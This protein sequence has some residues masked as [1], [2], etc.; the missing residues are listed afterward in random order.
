MDGGF[1]N[2]RLLDV[3]EELRVEYVLG[4]PANL[5]LLRR[6]KRFLR[7]LRKEAKKTGE[8]QRR[9]GS[10]SY[11]ARSWSRGRRVV[12]K[13]EV[14]VPPSNARG[15]RMKPNLRFVVTNLPNM[16]RQVYEDVYCARGDSENRIKEL[17]G[18]LQIDRTS[19]SS[20]RANQLRVL[21]TATAYALYQETRW[22]LRKDGPG[23]RAGGN[24]P[25]GAGETGGAGR[26]VRP[27]RRPAPSRLLSS[28]EIV[29]RPRS[30]PG[31]R[32]RLTSGRVGETVRPWGRGRGASR[33]RRIGSS[34][35][36]STTP[37]A[38]IDAADPLE[39]PRRPLGPRY[40]RT[41]APS[42]AVAHVQ[43][44]VS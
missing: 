34:E 7:G 13:A 25:H 5:V 1:V 40:P 31:C 10:F 2:S 37:A 6:S 33:C 15:R 21:M 4:V 11:E 38:P 20:Y 16:A 17:K 44:G 30:D 41:H 42:S 28:R 3:L 12:A 32:S 43:A 36:V 19:C 22:R 27:P 24:D 35:R 14:L 29:V 9:Y 23:H 8:S 26:D 18:D 39:P